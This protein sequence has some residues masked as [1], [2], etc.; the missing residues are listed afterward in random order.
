MLFSTEG[1]TFLFIIEFS[2]KSGKHGTF[3]LSASTAATHIF[4]APRTLCIKC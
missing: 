4:T 2:V 1:G 3:Y